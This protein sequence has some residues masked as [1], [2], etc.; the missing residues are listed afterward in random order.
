MTRYRVSAVTESSSTVMLR[1]V[2]CLVRHRIEIASLVCANPAGSA[3]YEYEMVV[4]APADHVRRAVKHIGALV[5]VVR[6]D[7]R[8]EED[9]QQ[10]ADE[11]A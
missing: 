8:M 10:S 2:A 9:Y 11:P 6:I 5:G 1:L 7:Y 3:V 4:L